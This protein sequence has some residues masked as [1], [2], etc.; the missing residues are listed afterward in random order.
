MINCKKL[1]PSRRLKY[2]RRGV[3][4]DVDDVLKVIAVKVD[5]STIPYIEYDFYYWYF[6]VWYILMYFYTVALL[7]LLK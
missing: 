3:C 2:L 5:K 6:M 1:P 4:G 7:L